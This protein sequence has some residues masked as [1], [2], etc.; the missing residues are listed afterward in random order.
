MRLTRR[1]GSQRVQALRLIGR[2]PTGERIDPLQLADLLVPQTPVTVQ[3]AVVQVLA[4]LEPLD[5]PAILLEG[6]AQHGPGIR[7]QI[8]DI[9]VSRE[10]WARGLLQSIEAGEVAA[11]ELG[12][13]SRSRL[14]LHF[15]ANV[16][17]LASQL[18]RESTP[19]ERL[20]TIERFRSKLQAPADANRGRDVFRKHCASCHQLEN[21]GTNIGPDL[22]AL[23]DRDPDKMLVSILDPDRAVEPRYVEYSVV[24]MR[25]RVLAGIVATET[26]NS[27]TLIDAQ[28]AEHKLVRSDVAELVST[29]KSLMPVGVEQ[30]LANDNELLDLIAYVRSVEKDPANERPVP[31]SP[32]PGK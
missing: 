25:G 2:S 15:S 4:R 27:L 10:A 28:G 5:L 13:T 11:N 17:R 12:A 19:V 32:L 14:I 8:V 18:M 26:G 7:P 23:T 9:L 16:R 6:W 21:E 3:I 31:I 20:S 29:G 1:W 30:L 22:L 24:T